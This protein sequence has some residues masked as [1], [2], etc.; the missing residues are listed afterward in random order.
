MGASYWSY[1]V[2]HDDVVERAFEKLQADVFARREYYGA[3][4]GRSFESIKSLVAFQA[5]EGTHS[6]LDM[7]RVV[8]A[9]APP[10]PTTEQLGQRLLAAMRGI[11]D[12]TYGTIFRMTDEELLA[13]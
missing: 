2:A 9:P 4:T 6:I 11:S 12:P 10:K 7:L 13:C 8:D 3:Q 5:D 1:V